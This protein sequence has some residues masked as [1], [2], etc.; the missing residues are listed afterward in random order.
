VKDAGEAM[1]GLA[2]PMQ[3][4][5]NNLVMVMQANLDSVLASLPPEDRASIRLARAAQATR[6]MDALLR[7]FLRL[8]RAEETPTLDSSRFLDSLR[9]LLATGIGRLLTIEVAATA[10]TAVARPAVDLALLQAAQGA[11]ALPRSTPATLVLEGLALRM[12]WA[13]APECHEALAAVGITVAEATAESST[14]R[15]P[16]GG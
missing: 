1:A 2:R 14:L 3:H 13:L 15:L 16:A 6:E 10:T 5:L 8:G 9:P 11:R 4:A 12:N 7:A